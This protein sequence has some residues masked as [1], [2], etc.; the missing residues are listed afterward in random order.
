MLSRRWYARALP[1]MAASSVDSA[2]GMVWSPCSATT[3][4]TQM[5]GSVREW[6]HAIGADVLVNSANCVARSGSMLRIA[7]LDDLKRGTRIRWLA[8]SL[9]DQPPTVVLSHEPDGIRQLDPR[10]R[11]DVMLAGHTH[12]G[13]IV[14]PW[15]GAPVTMSRTCGRRSAHGWVPN[16]R[17]PLLRH[18]RTW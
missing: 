18:A 5:P 1:A 13:Q 14:I 11:V 17:A 8:A 12:G 7:G 9:I 6:L 15:Y 10:L 2:H 3:T 16:P 4:T